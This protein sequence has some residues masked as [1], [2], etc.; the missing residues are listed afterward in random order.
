M[1]WIQMQSTCPWLDPIFDKPMRETTLK[2]RSGRSDEEMLVGPT[3]CAYVQHHCQWDGCQQL[4]GSARCC[5]LGGRWIY[6]YAVCK[7]WLMP[8]NQEDTV[9]F[10]ATAP[11]TSAAVIVCSFYVLTDKSTQRRCPK[12]VPRRI[13]DT[14]RT[15]GTYSNQEWRRP[16]LPVQLLLVVPDDTMPTCATT[17]PQQHKTSLL[18]S[19]SECRRR[20]SK[21]SL[22]ASIDWPLT[23]IIQLQTPK[24]A[25]YDAAQFLL[26]HGWRRDVAA[27]RPTSLTGIIKSWP[28]LPNSHIS[29]G[30]NPMDMLDRLGQQLTPATWLASCMQQLNPLVEIDVNFS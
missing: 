26:K 1:E 13:Q 3:R 24:L 30:L 7:E 16:K 27:M 11:T 17:T 23:L 20:S 9:P 6:P 14:N 25:V 22:F 29:V 2:I 18:H 28:R 12:F 8:F 15:V 21:K 4:K 10:P 19:C 5:V